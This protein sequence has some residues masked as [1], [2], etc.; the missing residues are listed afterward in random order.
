MIRP[1]PFLYHIGCPLVVD[2]SD[3][4]T[5]STPYLLL[6][7]TH[8]LQLINLLMASARLLPPIGHYGYSSDALLRR[9]LIVTLLFMA[10]ESCS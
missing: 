2:S 7:A 10:E 8:R 5:S 6:L 1:R 9:F 4:P 3:A